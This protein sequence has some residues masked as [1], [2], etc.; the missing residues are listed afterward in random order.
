ML[1]SASAST[2]SKAETGALLSAKSDAISSICKVDD[3]RLTSRLSSL[4][5]DTGTLL[6]TKSDATSSICIVF[7]PL[8]TSRSA[9]SIPADPVVGGLEF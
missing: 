1:S 7:D 5:A 4:G 2:V 3:S 8:P 6:V 9:L